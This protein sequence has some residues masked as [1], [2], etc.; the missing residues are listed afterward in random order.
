MYLAA[1]AGEAFAPKV[2]VVRPGVVAMATRGPSRYFGGDRA[3]AGKAMGTDGLLVFRWRLGEHEVE[4]G[5]RGDDR[6]SYPEWISAVRAMAA[7]P[8]RGERT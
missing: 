6:D 7:D 4:S 1:A 5:V 8:Q 3:L 2:E